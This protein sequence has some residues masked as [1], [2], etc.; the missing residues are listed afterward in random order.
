[1]KCAVADPIERLTSGGPDERRHVAAFLFEARNELIHADCVNHFHR[2]LQPVVAKLHGVVD[3]HQGLVDVG[4]QVRGITQ[5]IRENFPGVLAERVVIC[6]QQSEITGQLGV[7]GNR[8]F[9]VVEFTVFETLK[10]QGLPTVA[11][12]RIGSAVKATAGSL[13]AE[14]PLTDHALHYGNLGRDFMEHVAFRENGHQAFGD[15]THEVDA[16]QVIQAEH[17]RFR[18]AHWPAENRIC[19]LRFQAHSEGSMQGRL[20][21]EYANP[22][23]EKSGRVVA[24]NDALT[25]ARFIECLKTLDNLGTRIGAAHNFQQPHVADWIEEMRNRKLR[26][27]FGRHVLDQQGDWDSGSIRGND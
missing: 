21:G 22:V 20:N 25:H 14:I 10:I 8:R 27:E 4:Y 6:N 12:R 19:F 9:A 13:V 18:D 7:D 5:C 24:D 1:M 3:R 26:T 16:D 11:V 15:I 17:A 2:S 23:A